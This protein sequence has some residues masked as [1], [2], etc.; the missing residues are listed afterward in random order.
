MF[1]K[2]SSRGISPTATS[3]DDSLRSS[4]RAQCNIAT[5][6]SKTFKTYLKS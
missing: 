3:S 6:L 2:G 1:D 4:I 5:E